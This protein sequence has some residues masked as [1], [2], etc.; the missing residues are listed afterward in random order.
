LPDATASLPNPNT[1]W[2]VPRKFLASDYPGNEDPGKAHEKIRRFLEFGVRHFID[3]TE[4]GEYGLPPYEA[5]LSE[6]SRAANVTTTYER[7]PIQD[8]SVPR[9]ANHL[10]EVLLRIDR[11]IR[12]GG[13]RYFGAISTIS[14]CCRPLYSDATTFAGMDLMT[15]KNRSWTVEWIETFDLRLG[16]CS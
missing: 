1:Y 14:W 16:A 8:L 6:E 13:A 3:L 12:E 10:S 4:P 9:D 2:V 5:I 15:G 7:L 11:R